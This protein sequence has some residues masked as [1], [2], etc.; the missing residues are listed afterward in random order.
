MIEH[1]ICSTYT[2]SNFI[3]KIECLPR[4]PLLTN[5]Q[6][7]QLYKIY[8]CKQEAKSFYYLLY[9]IPAGTKLMIGF[10]AHGLS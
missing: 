2:V 6:L 9:G 1:F 4:N 7:K 8:F 5:D 10:S 3:L